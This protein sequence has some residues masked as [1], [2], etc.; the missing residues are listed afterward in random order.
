MQRED[1]T[2]MIVLQKIKKQLTWT[3]LAEVIGHSKEWSTAALLGQMTLTAAQAH[4]VGAALELSEET[5]ALLQVTPYKGSLPT[6]VPTDP[7]I[8]RFYEAISV[9]GTTFKAL[10]HEEFGDGIMSAIDFNMDLTREP[11][12]KGD[13]VRIVMSGKFLP[14]KTY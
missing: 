12:P 9:Y 7:L 5:I 2:E 10:I 8:Y 3:Q 4:A 13:R 14:Y 11:D 6:A 1:V